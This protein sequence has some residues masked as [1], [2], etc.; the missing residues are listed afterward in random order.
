MFLFSKPAMSYLRCGRLVAQ[1]LGNAI[2][3]DAKT[4]LEQTGTTTEEGKWQL[5]RELFCYRLFAFRIGSQ[6]AF[7]AD[8]GGRTRLVQAIGPIL[9][10]S[11]V[12]AKIFASESQFNELVDKRGLA[13]RDAMD[14][15]ARGAKPDMAKAL[16]NLCL[17]FAK[18]VG[19]SNPA[20]A[21][22]WAARWGI[23]RDSDTRFVNLL[24]RK[25]RLVE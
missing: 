10:E 18:N 19:V 2:A 17:E 16:L 11:F 9:V 13:Y 7:D 14:G 4:L 21:V 24:R 23:W 15:S 22:T 8:K 12:N 20:V 25:Y 6:V 3:D 1:F 5:L